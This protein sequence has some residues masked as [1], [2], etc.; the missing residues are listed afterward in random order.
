MKKKMYLATFF[1]MIG[2]LVS[3][4]TYHFT[5][6]SVIFSFAI[7]FGTTFYHFAIR[8]AVGHLIDQ[9]FHNHMDYKKTWFQE[10]AL[11]KKLYKQLKVKNWKKRFPTF[12]PR[13]FSLKDHSVENIIQVTCQAEIVHEI[14]MALSFVP[15]LFSVWFGS[16]DVFLVTSCLAFLFDGVFVIIQRYNRPRL[17]RLLR[18]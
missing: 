10:K 16:F 15:V 13:D 9:R 11:E 6:N 3:G 14:N 12:N 18:K 17:I 8:L 1:F 2:L 7:T 4:L 5:R